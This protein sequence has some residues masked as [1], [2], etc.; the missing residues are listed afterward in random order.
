MTTPKPPLFTRYQKEAVAILAFLQFTIVLDFM[1][2]SPLGALLMDQLKIT[3][4]QFGW[5]VSAYA[6][7]A[8]VSGILAAGFADKF[9]RKKLLLFFYTGFLT[10]TLLCGIAPTYH[11][12]LGARIIT[13]IFGGV[14]GAISLAIVADLFA[15]EIR[16]RVMGFVQS[17]FA[18]AQVLGLPLGLWISNKFSWHAPFLM[19]VGVSSLVGILIFL[20]LKPLD[21]H[22]KIKSDRNPLKHLL[23]TITRGRYLG[24]FAATTLLAT[25]GFMLMP[26]ASAFS[27]HNLGIPLDKLPLVYMITGIGAGIGGPLLGKLSDTIG[28]Y[29]L[30]CMGSTLGLVVVLFYCN[31]G[32]TPLWEVILV[33]VVLFIAITARMITANTLISGV[34]DMQDRGAFMSINGSVAQLAGGLAAMLAGLIVVQNADGSLGRYNVL[35]AVVAVAM[36]IVMALMYNVNRI[37]K[38]HIPRP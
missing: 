33:N 10:G 38:S 14:L 35:G 36:A 37:V 20:R 32:V 24:A 8:G 30:F 4:R 25:G 7:S 12:L 19:I 22:L 34:P 13:G 2:L 23:K 5:V 9:D 1:I 6:F 27:V 16:G 18:A 11:L 3:T 28:K 29:A 21:A 17:S 26:F 15:M 31:L